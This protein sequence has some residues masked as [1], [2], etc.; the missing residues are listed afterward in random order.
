M[1]VNASKDVKQEKYSSIAGKDAAHIATM[2]TNNVFP[3]KV[4]IAFPQN[5]DIPFS[6]MY[7]IETPSC[8]KVNF[9]VMFIVNLFIIARIWKQARYPSTEELMKIWCIDTMK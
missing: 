7:P 8:H 6:D 9:S 1:T 2:E 4:R 3:R 5:P